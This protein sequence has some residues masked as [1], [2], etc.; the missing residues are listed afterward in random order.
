MGFA[1]REAQLTPKPMHA[2]LLCKVVDNLGDAGVCARLARQLA[3]EYGCAVR[4]WTDQPELL[5]RFLLHPPSDSHSRESGNP[6][7][8][9]IMP[10]S[11]ALLPS[12]DSRFRGNDYESDFRNADIIILLWPTT[13]PLLST[14]GDMVIEAFACGTPPELIAAMKAAP[15]PPLWVNL[16][17]LSAE[18]WVDDCHGR[19]SLH[20]SGLKQVFFFPGFTDRT[21]GLL[22][23][24]SLLAE[25]E[26]FE[27]RPFWQSLNVPDIPGELRISLFCYPTAPVED[28]IDGL[29]AAHRPIRLL[30]PEGLFSTLK[31]KD[32]VVVQPFSFLPQPAF[33]RLLWASDLNFVRGEDSL[34]RGCWA[35][36]PLIWQIYKQDDNAH[37]R[38]L[39]AFLGRLRPFLSAEAAETLAL[40]HQVWNLPARDSSAVWQRLLGHLPDIMAA[41]KTWARQLA[42]RKDL[43]RQLLQLA[44]DPKEVQS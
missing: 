23:E 22:R 42:A 5:S 13:F 2:E 10:S 33:D 6:E 16:E 36:K 11:I 30:Y 38:K 17:Y 24:R 21:G 1:T 40:A 41:A 7:S 43:A 20:P 28:L 26:A 37:F 34:V 3:D 35:A 39:E 19:I 44:Q 15:V 29:A 4:L 25:R 9:A 31:S 8:V 12:M 27:P 18:E 32:Q 14:P